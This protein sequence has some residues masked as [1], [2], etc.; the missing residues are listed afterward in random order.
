MEKSHSPCDAIEHLSATVGVCRP[1]EQNLG[2]VTGWCIFRES[3]CARGGGSFWMCCQYGDWEVCWSI[4][5]V[6]LSTTT[7][8]EGVSIA[9]LGSALGPDSWTMVVESAE[10]SIA[11]LVSAWGSD[12]WTM[13]VESAMRDASGVPT[14]PFVLVEDWPRV[15][16]RSVGIKR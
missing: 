16:M 12:S 3:V 7:G 8:T 4:I 13:A 1:R 2:R 14:S 5:R 10:V 11:G 15:L 6:R 9:G